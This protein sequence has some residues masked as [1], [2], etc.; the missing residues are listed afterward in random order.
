[1]ALMNL[2][3][4]LTHPE[5]FIQP[6]SPEILEEESDEPEIILESHLQQALSL[7]NAL[8][9]I[10]GQVDSAAE[11][12]DQKLDATRNKI[13]LANML[14][15]TITLCLSVGTLVGGFMGMNVTNHIEEDPNAFAQITFGTLT[16]IAC[17]FAFI[18][19]ILYYS[20]TIVPT[21]SAD[22]MEL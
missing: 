8:D 2:S 7:I 14:I 13:L 15:S 6:V 4:L 16:G 3:R 19:S 21:A 20:G 22:N 1:M 18:L 11:L 5:R 12:I 9:L 17:L 10:K